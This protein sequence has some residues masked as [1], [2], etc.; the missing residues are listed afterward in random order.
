MSTVQFRKLTADDGRFGTASN[1]AR[2]LSPKW[3]ASP[4][5]SNAHRLQMAP[6]LK[7]A[8][9]ILIRDMIEDGGF[10]NEE[11]AEAASCTDRTVKA[12]DRNL[13]LFGSTTAAP[14]R[15]GRPRSITP[16]MLDSLLDHLGPAPILYL[17]EM[18]EY[19][20]KEFRVL[21]TQSSMS[22]TL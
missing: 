11:I 12:I 16:A 22:R 14:N 7:P 4:N 6:N 10:K 20:W 17:E 5:S 2:Y 9:R 15:G 19:L 8:K 21:T 3:P 18:V 13:R 1:L